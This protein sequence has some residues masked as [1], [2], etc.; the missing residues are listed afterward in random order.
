MSY[1]PDTAPVEGFVPMVLAGGSGTRFW[2]R[3]RRARAKQV[4]AL[5]GERTMIQDTFARLLPSALI[6]Q[7]WIVANDGLAGAVRE[8]LPQLPQE[9]LICEPCAR[10]TAPACGLVAYIVRRL[11]PGAVLGVFPSDH[12]VTDRMRFTQVL[13]AGVEL[14]RERGNIVVLGAPPSHPETGYG[15]IEQGSACKDRQTGD[16]PVQS[17]VRFTEKPDFDTALRFVESKRYVWNSGMFLWSAQTLCEALEEYTPQL[18]TLLEKIAAAYGT[19][20]FETVFAELYPQC[21]NVSIDYAV[22]EPRSLKGS[23]SGIFCMPADFG[24]NDLGSWSALYQHRRSMGGYAT[25]SNVVESAASV[26]IEAS[27]NYVYAPGRHVALLGVDN[28]VVV[29]TEDAVLVTRQDRSQDVGKIVKHLTQGGYLQ[30][31]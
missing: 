20:E 15:Y 31:T 16:V 25:G 10:N 13:R 17:V 24:W 26:H 27:S 21:Q 1:V 8:Q 6:D 14:A 30:L 3:S 2:P 5:D 29:L 12:V 11:A 4:L 19:P 9:H 22:I 23:Q 18:A 7:T 28:L